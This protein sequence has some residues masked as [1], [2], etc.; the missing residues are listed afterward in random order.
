M[1]D[2]LR[3]DQNSYFQKQN[4][5]ALK[6]TEVT[7]EYILDAAV[8][9][10]AGLGKSIRSLARSLSNLFK[11]GEVGALFDPSTTGTLYTTTA[12]ILPAN[13]GDPVG[14][15]LD[16]SQWGG[17]ALGAV[18]G[19]ELVTNGTF[20][21]DTAWS[22]TGGTTISGGAGNIDATGGTS[23]LF[24]DVFTQGKSYIVDF[25][26]LSVTGS[27]QVINNAGS[28][29]TTAISSPGSKSF[30]FTHS[31]V[32]GNLLFRCL[33]GSNIAS[34]DN[35]SVREVTVANALAPILG[36]ELV[37]NGTFDTDTT[38]WVGGTYVVDFDFITASAS[39]PTVS[40]YFGSS[41]GASNLGTGTVSV[42][43]SSVTITATSTTTYIEFGKA[44]QV[45]SEFT[46]FDNVSVKEIPGY[47]ATQATA[48]KR[49][50]YGIHPFG[51][52]RNLTTASEDV[53]SNLAISAGLSS[54]T[55]DSLTFS[56]TAYAYR[57]QNTGTV[58]GRTFIFSAVLSS[59]TKA[60]I[61]FRLA[62]KVTGTD[63]TKT[64]IALTATPTRYSV[65]RTFTSADV[66][67]YFGFDNRVAGGYGDGIAGQ[68][69]IT[70]QQVEQ[71]A[72]ATDYQKVTSQ[73]V[74]TET[75]VPSVHYLAFDGVDDAMATP[76]I[77]FSASDEM[78]VF[79]GVRKLSTSVTMLSELSANAGS[80]A[81][82][83]YITA[84]EDAANRYRFLSRGTL[85]GS[86]LTD[87]A[88][89]D[90]PITN[91]LTAISKI[92]TPNATL[93]VDGVQVGTDAST[94]GTG[95]F[96]NHPLYIGSRAGTSIYFKGHLYGLTVRGALSDAA[97]IADA[98]AITA[99][100]T[101][102]TL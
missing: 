3:N 81:G 94:Q 19:S 73:Y 58:T 68:V 95:N 5:I 92:S 26:V 65:T 52:R 42:G 36:P 14:L 78:S 79:A 50:I 2:V 43:S 101:G 80:S 64:I 23:L 70:D 40:Y 38:G 46:E 20:D 13:P 32:S 69:T 48:A 27:L 53:S 9:R 91:L 11:S 99:E 97:E 15:M 89:Y 98:E 54:V 16:Q 77:D 1:A 87:S 74:V 88:L 35:V 41:V 85:I 47:H 86:A 4:H 83:F 33:V 82:A 34:I 12:M 24:Q 102:I 30:T 37:T 28:S 60:T 25:D 63:E 100:L 72:T 93:R 29:L 17:V 8:Q 96:G 76:S 59:A 39:D 57:E 6:K 61:G 71:S 31:D 21:T 44:G 49:P 62:G 75:G 7:K 18:Y 51:G 56:S 10:A 67:I 55:S 90:A 84:P 66:A 22:K 45:A